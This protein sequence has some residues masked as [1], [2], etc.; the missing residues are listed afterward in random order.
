MKA[1][2]LRDR[3]PSTRRH[4]FRALMERGGFIREV[5]E[6]GPE[7]YAALTHVGDNQNILSLTIYPFM[8]G[9]TKDVIDEASP[10]LNWLLYESPWKKFYHSFH[11]P[12][13][14][15]YGI[16]I[17]TPQEYRAALQAAI[18]IREVFDSQTGQ[19]FEDLVDT[20][21][22]DPRVAH[23]LIPCMRKY[24]DDMSWTFYPVMLGDNHSWNYSMSDKACR[25]YMRGTF[26]PEYVSTTWNTY[27]LMSCWD[28]DLGKTLKRETASYT[29]WC[30]PYFPRTDWGGSHATVY[31]P[32]MRT[33]DRDKTKE[34]SDRFLEEYG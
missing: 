16:T 7:C 17:S 25:N 23:L 21:G 14:E 9:D 8:E 22:M 13:N 26:D 11:D 29:E 18:C 32:P 3:E 6:W 24:R 12:F 34:M 2:W 27:C 4:S 5:V 20:L 28:K 10:Y 33:L 1:G 19:I 15:G 30:E 31:G